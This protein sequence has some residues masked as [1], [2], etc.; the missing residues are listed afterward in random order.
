M[1]IITDARGMTEWVNE[2]FERITGFRLEEI[3][4]LPPG[5]LLQGPDT[6]PATVAFMRRCL[7]RG[8]GFDVDIVNY[9]KE[10]VPYWVRLEV[11]PVRDGAGRITNFTAIETEITDRKRQEQQ[12]A[13]ALVFA[14]SSL[15]ALSSHVAILNHDGV[16]LATNTAWRRFAERNGASASI[17]IGVNYL[18]VCDNCQSDGPDGCGA[19]AAAVARGVRDVISRDRD[20]FELEYPC[21]GP[22]VQRWY[23]VRA[24]RFP[25]G[26]PDCVVVSHE[27][28]TERKLAELNLERFAMDLREA[29][30]TLEDQAVELH[31]ARETA[32]HANNA[33][34]QFLANMSHEIRT[35]MTAILGYAD[36]LIERPDDQHDQAEFLQTIRRNGK[37]LLAILDDILDLSKIEAGRMTVERIAVDLPCMLA[38]VTSLF[39]LRTREKDLEFRFEQH[40]PLPQTVRTDPTR[41]RQV[42]FNLL[43][44]AVK[45]TRHGGVRL[46]VRFVP[47]D[48]GSAPPALE[49]S[50]AD[51]GI[52]MSEGQITKLFKPF[53]QADAS[54]TRRFGGTGLGLVLCQRLTEMLGGDI[55]VDSAPGVGST[56]TIRLSAGRIDDETLLSHDA[57]AERMRV[58]DEANMTTPLDEAAERADGSH[59][60]DRPRRVL[61]VEDGPDNQRLVAFHLRRAGY[62]VDLAENGRVGMDRALAAKLT[63]SPHDAVLMD[64]QMPEMDGYAATAELRKAGYTPPIIALTAHAMS[65]DRERCLT[66]GCDDYLAKPIDPKLLIATLDAHIASPT[67]RTSGESSRGAGERARRDGGPAPQ[68]I[69]AS[70]AQAA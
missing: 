54:T 59:T 61:L 40:S 67:K 53:S 21:H 56:F 22:D 70:D 49:F 29:N 32:E 48:G 36:L 3:R 2:P 44:N 7:E 66:A 11:Q 64:M 20:S 58:A 6:D 69:D 8:E 33:K 27:N 51:S 23:V 52:G 60:P 4:G 1:V 13:E 28:V 26:G 5:D 50:I 35:P 9:T 38:D 46:G 34:S 14:R 25:D 63:G 31:R 16:I 24:T 62:E 10:R 42:L 19:E 43:G 57:F 15:D 65:G 41:L 12:L 68:S 55:R 45:F 17:G 30:R 18:D 39:R 47:T 37:H